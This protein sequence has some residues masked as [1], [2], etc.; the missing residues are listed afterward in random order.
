M[1]SVLKSMRN[2][3]GASIT[4]FFGFILSR[5]FILWIIIHVVGFTIGIRL[6]A[7]ENPEKGFIFSIA[8]MISIYGLISTLVI[9]G[10]CTDSFSGDIERGMLEI[11]LVMPYSRIE[12]FFGKFFSL[13]YLII[14]AAIL[15][16]SNAIFLSIFYGRLPIR[17]LL[18]IFELTIVYIIYMICI[19]SITSLISLVLKNNIS[20]ITGMIAYSVSMV[21]VTLFYPNYEYV[22]NVE[23]HSNYRTVIMSPYYGLSNVIQSYLV[24]GYIDIIAIGILFLFGIVIMIISMQLFKGLEI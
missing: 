9:I 1:I 20:T 8:N 12:L 10:F 23:Y 19:I 5:G 7:I 24:N 11:K 17:Y 21:I 3:Y 16:F 13:I 18:V 2:A 4:E 14:I 6:Y 22:S 15:F